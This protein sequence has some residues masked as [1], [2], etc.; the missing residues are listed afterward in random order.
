MMFIKGEMRIWREMPHTFWFLRRMLRRTCG[1]SVTKTAVLLY[2]EGK[3]IKDLFSKG[4]FRG[5][6]KRRIGESMA[7]ELI[8]NVTFSE[9]K[10]PFLENGTLVE[11]YRGEERKEHGRQ[12]IQGKGCPIVP[13][14]MRIYRYRTERSAFLYVGDIILD[15][16]M[17]EEFESSDSRSITMKG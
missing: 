10:L 14:M 17:Y 13:G 5:L 7:A 12:H 15:R 1:R 2:L 9:T 3:G 16:M 4:I 6:L 8:I 11:F